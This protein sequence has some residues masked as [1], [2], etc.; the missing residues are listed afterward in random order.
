M[1]WDPVKN[2]NPS[3]NN[4]THTLY[5]ADRHI[6]ERAEFWEEVGFQLERREVPGGYLYRTLTYQGVALAFVPYHD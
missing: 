2:V 3:P 5:T 1:A 6:K 4:L